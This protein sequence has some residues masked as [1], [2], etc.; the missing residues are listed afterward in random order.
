[1]QWDGADADACVSLLATCILETPATC[2]KGTFYKVAAAAA[3]AVIG[4]G[5]SHPISLFLTSALDDCSR[6]RAAD[7][8]VIERL[9]GMTAETGQT[10]LADP[11]TALLAAER[12]FHE[13]MAKVR[14]ESDDDASDALNREAWAAV[15]RMAE[16]PAKSLAGAAA[17]L[18]IVLDEVG[19]P[20]G[21][22]YSDVPMLRDVLAVVERLA[23]APA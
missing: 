18:R 20:A 3:A 9:A 21:E 11:D 14:T 13:M 16:T 12:R 22:S 23:E 8:D 5:E 6:L 19:L 10:G 4:L 2:H 1:M 15:D 17:K 7:P